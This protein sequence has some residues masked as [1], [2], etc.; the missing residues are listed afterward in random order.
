MEVAAGSA[1]LDSNTPEI[2][3]IIITENRFKS[4]FLD[5][6]TTAFIVVIITEKNRFLIQRIP[7][8]IN[9]MYYHVFV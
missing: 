3:V 7:T 2:I 5:S 9:T 1:F 6:N 4:A 8:S